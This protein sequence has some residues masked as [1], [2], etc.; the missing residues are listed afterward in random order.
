MKQ[1]TEVQHRH[2]A[3]VQTNKAVKTY[4][5]IVK[6]TKGNIKILV[7]FGTFALKIHV[8]NCLYRKS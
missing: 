1:E 6:N 2:T 3:C 8:G 5:V 7:G 4:P